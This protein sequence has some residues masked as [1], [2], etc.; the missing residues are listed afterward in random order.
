MA[1]F[2]GS[3]VEVVIYDASKRYPT[4]REARGSACVQWWPTRP[5]RLGE[6][7]LV[8]EQ[9]DS[10][11]QWD[12]QRLIELA[13][14]AGCRDRARYDTSALRPSSCWPCPMGWRGAGRGAGSGVDTA[15]RDCSR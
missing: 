11:V 9:D 12:G 8:L 7:R 3:G 4:D 6:T 15:R 10:L 2:V 5:P 14:A 1:A 13:R